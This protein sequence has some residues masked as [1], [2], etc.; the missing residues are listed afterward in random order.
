MPEGRGQHGT[1]ST[2]GRRG[3][4]PTPTAVAGVSKGP[5]WQFEHTIVARVHQADD[6]A[7]YLLASLIARKIISE[8]YDSSSCS[9][10]HSTGQGGGTAVATRN[11]DA[12]HRG[13]RVAADGPSDAKRSS[14]RGAND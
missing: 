13:F 5:K 4:S 12:S 7:L 6:P 2:T 11:P 14:K 10:H 3:D 8:D 9:S 1:V